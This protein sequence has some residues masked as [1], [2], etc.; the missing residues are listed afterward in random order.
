MNQLHIYP[1]SR[2]LRSISQLLRNSDGFLPALMRMDEFEKRAVLLKGRTQIDSLQRI[3]FLREA[4]KF[5]DFSLLKVDRDLIRFFAKSEALFKFFEELSAEHVSFDTLI[6]ADP[7]AEFDKHIEV[8]EKLRSRYKM[9][10]DEKGLTDKTFIPGEYILNEGF[11]KGYGQIDIYLEGYLSRF[12]LELLQRSAEQTRLIIHYS[13]S[14]FNRKMLERFEA[15]G[16]LLKEDRDVSFDLGAERILEDRENRMQIQASVF[17]VEERDEQ[18][19]LAFIKIE[20]MVRSGI[21]PEE[22]VLVLPD[23]DFKEHFM[24][25]DT[26]NNLNFSMGYDY[27]NG[28]IYKLLEALHTYLQRRDRESIDVLERYGLSVEEIDGLNIAEPLD[29]DG[30]FG[31]LREM[32][33]LDTEKHEEIKE[34]YHHFLILFKEEKL[35]YREWL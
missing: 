15:C 4:S 22:I 19:A 16:I 8:L 28:R 12:E 7:Y 10:L 35:R 14:M 17:S 11:L 18:V 3:L 29:I 34:R 9:L 20:E 13:T 27:R 32:A 24:L 21:A 26:W 2:A 23:E 31:I 25:F 33:L 30:F 6:E 5:K 1:T